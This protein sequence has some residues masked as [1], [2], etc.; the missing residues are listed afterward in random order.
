MK[1][2]KMQGHRE[3]KLFSGEKDTQ[4]G[5]EYK[6]SC[7]VDVIVQLVRARRHAF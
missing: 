5:G 7:W 3:D 4:L 1:N 6:E 2:K